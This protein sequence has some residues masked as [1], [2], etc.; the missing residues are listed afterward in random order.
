MTMAGSVMF[1]TNT[2]ESDID[3]R[4]ICVPPKN[5]LLGFARNFEQQEVP[6]EDTVIF[7]L[8]R[9]MQLSAE[10][11]PNILEIL[12]A[13][14]DC[15]LVTHPTWN[16]FKKHRQKFLVADV[17]PRFIGYATSQMKRMESHKD[18][19]LKP[20][21]KKPTRAD[22]G[23]PEKSTGGK[24]L[25]KQT[26]D[27]EPLE[28]ALDVIRRE[29]AYKEASTQWKQYED[30]KQTRNPK[31]YA[32]EVK[33]GYDSKNGSHLLRTLRTLK[34]LLLTGE[35]V[36]RR[37]DAKELLAIRQGEWP[38]DKLMGEVTE[39][40]EELSDVY[41]NKK[42]VVPESLNRV[43]LSDVCMELHEFH[44]SLK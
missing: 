13:P 10:G 8:K 37:P 27:E 20:L 4:G 43:E 42:Y 17:F 16:E 21:T 31:R 6:G 25:S 23:L 39:L 30:W 35:M 26:S 9:I 3:K 2:P 44:W 18:W 28:V 7:A 32:I 40:R 36:V 14:E 38:L 1:G 11:N 22:Y 15:H 29:K 5:Y 24:E 41:D 12:F 34:D 33:I 19:I